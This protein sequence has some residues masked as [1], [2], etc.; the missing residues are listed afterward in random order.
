MISFPPTSLQNALALLQQSMPRTRQ[1]EPHMISL[2]TCSQM[3][4]SSTTLTTKAE[5]F[6]RLSLM[7]CERQVDAPIERF[8]GL[9]PKDLGL[10]LSRP[11][12][13]RRSGTTTI[14]ASTA[15]RQKLPCDSFARFVLM[16]CYTKR[17]T[18][19]TELLSC[20]R[21]LLQSFEPQRARMWLAACSPAGRTGSGAVLPSS[22][23]VQSRRGD[24]RHETDPTAARLFTETYAL[25]SS[26]LLS[27]AR[28]GSLTLLY[29][30]C[31]VGVP[32]E[33]SLSSSWR[34][35]DDIDL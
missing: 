12:L 3:N 10:H 35:I 26:A 23:S 24:R 27:S 30:M 16:W 7:K 33:A 11:A 15:D 21:F 13:P 31:C 20:C 34:A 19:R 1:V 28:L 8:T 25:L 18:L 2:G 29:S 17:S 5:V 6:K 14:T 32:Q 9:P 22:L 4:T